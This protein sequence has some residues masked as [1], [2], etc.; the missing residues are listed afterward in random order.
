MRLPIQGCY[1]A[2]AMG[3][4]G[5]GRD[6]SRCSC[7]AVA[8]DL[9]ALLALRAALPP[10]AAPDTALRGP[11][12]GDRC[13][14]DMDVQG[15]GRRG[16]GAPGLRTTLVGGASVPRAYAGRRGRVVLRGV[17]FGMGRGT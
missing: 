15:P 5:R 17:S 12:V 1:A 14:H 7:D 13:G 6:R 9:A 3:S 11:W 4:R 8:R 2:G 16:T 10:L